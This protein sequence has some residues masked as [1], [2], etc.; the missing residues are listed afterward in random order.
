MQ[1]FNRMYNNLKLVLHEIQA[2]YKTKQGQTLTI[3]TI[4][5]NI[6]DITEEKTDNYFFPSVKQDRFI[7]VFFP[8]PVGVC[9]FT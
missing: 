1:K 7:R 5:C 9:I 6:K 2:G 4:I 8:L 3:C